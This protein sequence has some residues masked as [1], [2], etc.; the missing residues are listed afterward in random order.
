MKILAPIILFHIGLVVTGQKILEDLSCDF[1]DA[2]LCN[3][4]SNDPDAAQF[5]NVFNQSIRSSSFSTSSYNVDLDY[6]IN[7]I[8]KNTSDRDEKEG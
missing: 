6:E 7:R 5:R 4:V 2:T 3:W 1:N 8:S